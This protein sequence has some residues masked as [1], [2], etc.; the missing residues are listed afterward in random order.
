[1]SAVI[2][3]QGMSKLGRALNIT[4]DN[5]LFE[6]DGNKIVYMYDSPHLLKSARNNLI[7]YSYEVDGYSSCFSHV[8]SVFDFFSTMAYSGVVKLT[9]AHIDPSIWEKMRVKLAAQVMSNSVACAMELLIKFKNLPIEAEGT[10][11]IV[12]KFDMLFD[13]LNASLHNHPNKF[14]NVYTG[15]AIQ[16][17]FFNETLEFLSRIRL[18][19]KSRPEIT[20]TCS[21]FIIEEIDKLNFKSKQAR[22]IKLIEKYKNDFSHYKKVVTG[23]EA[24]YKFIDEVE[25]FIMEIRVLKNNKTKTDVTSKVYVC[26]GSFINS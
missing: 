22:T 11:K 20:R 21:L 5:P 23:S 26:H 4:P 7:K 3:D 25:C 6:V 18:I 17:Q 1:M 14:K 24:Y 19:D 12:S 13:T 15:S 9:P 10:A 2:N 16:K 8:R